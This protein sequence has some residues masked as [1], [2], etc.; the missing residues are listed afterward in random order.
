MCHVSHVYVS[1]DSDDQGHHFRA[2]EKDSNSQIA[3]C[4][5]AMQ[6]DSA[7]SVIQ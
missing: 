6:G 2:P 5:S 7:H 1:D 4:H 3:V